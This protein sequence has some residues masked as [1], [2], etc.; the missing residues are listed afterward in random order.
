MSESIHLVSV[1][2]PTYNRPEGLRETLMSITSQ[3]YPNLEIIVADNCTPGDATDI[4]IREFLKKDKRI[5]YYRHAENKGASFNFN[6][7]VQ[8]A[9]GK[10]FM[11]AADDDSW[12]ENYIAKCVA[13]LDKAPQAILCYSDLRFINQDGNII[14]I[15]Y[16]GYDNPDLSSLGLEEI[17]KTIMG[18]NGWYMIYGIY[19]RDALK[20][21]SIKGSYGADVLMTLELCLKGKFVKVPEVLFFYRQIEKKTEKDRYEILQPENKSR[22]LL[23]PQCDLFISLLDLV[24]KAGNFSLLSKVS[25]YFELSLIWSSRV[26]EYFKDFI[27]GKLKTLQICDVLKLIPMI[28][29][30]AFQKI[31]SCETTYKIKT[32]LLGI[33]Q[34]A[35]I[36]LSYTQKKKKIRCAVIEYNYYHDHVLPTLIYCLNKLSVEVHLFTSYENYIKDTFIYTKGLNY[37]ACACGSHFFPLKKFPVFKHFEIFEKIFGY[38]NYDFIF[39]NS[40]EPKTVLE[41]VKNFNVPILANVHNAE[42]VNND[43]DYS[44]FFNSGKRIP[45]FMA[46]FIG[47]H[48]GFKDGNWIMPIYNCPMTP[49][50]EPSSEVIFCVSGNFSYEKRNYISLVDAVEKLDRKKIGNFVIRIIGNTQGFKEFTDFD[51]SIKEKNLKK[52]FEIYG[53]NISYERYYKL[54]SSSNFS[55]PLIDKTRETFLNYYSFKLTSII[56]LSIELGV[57]S[58]LHEDLA[59]MYNIEDCSIK[60]SDNRLDEALE[61]A[62]KLRKEDM[63][64]FARKIKEKKEALTK[65]CVDNIENKLKI[66]NVF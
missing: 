23:S 38:G 53:D 12:D 44:D 26:N 28:M 27:F 20:N 11:W 6:F 25:L 9:H 35:S 3:T 5:R 19:R 42:L 4:V 48:V 61:Y 29:I 33:F 37:K 7:V 65:A 2:I 47:A 55:L 34:L 14:N 31:R 40:L 39:V 10:Y 63:E 57:I 18:R 36:L 45:F 49:V 32:A 64:L 17:V 66:I 46:D 50:N 62:I 24:L 43:R 8:N 54:V 15:D 56:P 41:R 52:Y 60:Y 1:G 51:N 21:I 13:A 58:V 30:K 16:S 59:V 22:K